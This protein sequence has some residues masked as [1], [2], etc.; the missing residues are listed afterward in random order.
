MSPLLFNITKVVVVSAFSAMV[1]EMLGFK[2]FVLQPLRLPPSAVSPH[3]CILQE[4]V[5]ALQGMMHAHT[6]IL[7]TSRHQRA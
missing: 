5:Q 2:L 6:L 7:I 4:G 3:A 1:S